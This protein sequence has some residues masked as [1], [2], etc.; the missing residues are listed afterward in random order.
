M[1]Q[2]S[3]QLTTGGKKENRREHDFYPTPKECTIALMDFLKLPP[4]K[5]IW[6][7][8]CGD[9][10]MAIVIEKYGHS[11]YASDLRTDCGFG[12]GGVDYLNKICNYYDAIITNPPFN[13]SAAFIEKA[14]TE[15]TVVAMLLKSQYWHSK[16]RYSLF[17]N[18]PPSFVL[19]LTWRPNFAPEKGSAPTMEVLWTVWMQGDTTTKY[20]PL[21]KPITKTNEDFGWKGKSKNQPEL[22]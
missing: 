14:I 21:N 12:E 16:N 6:E 11:I 1:N 2:E 17:M 15:A 9:G 19:P 5:K 20:I 10:S 3:L 13:L 22:F 8:A 7:P 4:S 18:N